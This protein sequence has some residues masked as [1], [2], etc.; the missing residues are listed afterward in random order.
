MRILY[1]HRTLGDGAE[2][3]HIREIVKGLRKLGHEVRVV[4]LISEEQL[5]QPN[6]QRSTSRWFWVK[7][8]I[9]GFVFELL[10]IFYNLKG[11]RML[12]KAAR[13]FQ[14]DAIYDRYISYN[15]SAIRAS[16]KL[17]IPCIAE[18]NSPYATQRRIW[19]R[20]YFPSLIQYFENK[21]VND[22]DKVIVVSTPLKNHLIQHGA[23]GD[24]ILVVPNGTNP[25][26]F[27]P[28]RAEE[29][30]KNKYKI[31]EL[32]VVLGFVGMLRKW[33]NIEMLLDVFKELCTDKNHLKLIF[34]GDGAIQSDLERCAEEIGVGK[35]VIF[36]G[37]VAHDQVPQHIALFHIAISPNVT[38]YSSPMKILEYMAM[39]KCVVAPDMENIRDILV[40]GKTGILFT[41]GNKSDL[42]NKLSKLIS[43]SKLRGQIG[44]C[45]RQAVIENFTW[46]N[47]AQKIVKILR[48][49]HH[50]RSGINMPIGVE[51]H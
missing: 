15:Y 40:P 39:G 24:N 8:I 3:I 50:E 28:V 23:K 32:D 43:S 41:P 29:T 20:I 2:G 30:L 19:E 13:D 51:Q 1:H 12:L 27:K 47:N 21:I 37:R 9:P 42:K 7:K 31:S 17:N 5:N 36:T 46:L 34:V 22:A 48:E 45:A 33:H 18:V 11:Y 35:S 14:P 25:A 38:Y 16:K 44:L 10:E 49:L 4:S 6:K 26:R